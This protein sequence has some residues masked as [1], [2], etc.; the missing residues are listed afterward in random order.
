MV[1]QNGATKPMDDELMQ[2]EQGNF[3]IP[4]VLCMSHTA[5]MRA[6]LVKLMDMI[7]HWL[8]AGIDNKLSI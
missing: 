6:E 1:C 8:E 2:L 5:D 7:T 3:V 4:S